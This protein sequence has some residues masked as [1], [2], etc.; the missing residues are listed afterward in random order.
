MYRSRRIPKARLPRG[1]ER[2]SRF[3]RRSAYG[4][5]GAALVL[6]LA[7]VGFGLASR[8][9]SNEFDSLNKK[10]ATEAVPVEQVTGAY[11]RAKRDALYANVLL[12]VGAA[13]ALAAVLLF[14]FLEPDGPATPVG[15]PGGLALRVRF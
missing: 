4:T 14:A 6:V 13:T 15:T 9:A 8:S 11:D 3:T 7:G 10:A 12:G 5:G 2:E 1:G